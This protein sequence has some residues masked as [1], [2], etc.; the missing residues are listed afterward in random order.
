MLKFFLA[1]TVRLIDK[2]M[3]TTSKNPQTNSQ[4]KGLNRKI[5]ARQ[6]HY[7]AEHQTD[8]GHYVHPLTYT[9]N[10]QVHRSTFTTPFSLV[11]SQ[12]PPGPSTQNQASAF[13]NDFTEPPEP[14]SFRDL[15]LRQLNLVHKQTDA[16]LKTAQACYRR[17]FNRTV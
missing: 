15:F 9:C 7:I 6:Q 5:V 14:I 16:K 12:Q 10:D 17:N 3:T 2:H 11:W 13:P 4:V 1:V 8:W